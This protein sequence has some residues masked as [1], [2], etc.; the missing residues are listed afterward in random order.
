VEGLIMAEAERPAREP[1]PADGDDPLRREEQL[2]RRVRK[3]QRR[4]GTNLALLPLP[5]PAVPSVPVRQQ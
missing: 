3:V 4:V 5:R 1:S 2:A